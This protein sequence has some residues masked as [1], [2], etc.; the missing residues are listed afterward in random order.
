LG[1]VEGVGDEIVRVNAETVSGDSVV[2]IGLVDDL[3]L[4]LLLTFEPDT[5]RT[6]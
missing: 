5:I 3:D 2:G 4:P 1:V 6:P